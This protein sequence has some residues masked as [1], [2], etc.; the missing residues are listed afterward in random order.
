MTNADRPALERL[1]PENTTGHPADTFDPITEKV[2]EG[3]NENCRGLY[4]MTGVTDASKD[5]DK[6]PY[7]SHLWAGY[8]CKRTPNKEKKLKT[9]FHTTAST[10]PCHILNICPDKLGMKLIDMLRDCIEKLIPNKEHRPLH[11]FFIDRGYLELAKQQDV[12]VF[13][14][15]QVMREL[16]VRFLGTVKNLLKYPFYFVKINEDGKTSINGRAV[17]QL[18]GMR[19][20]LTA[21][22]RNSTPVYVQN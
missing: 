2:I 6:L 19:T 13:N 20:A 12:D 8:G 17:T 4:F 1:C 9:C 3:F 14:L 16:G 18:Y 22:S 5:D 21:T 7:C 15:I 10:A 11:T